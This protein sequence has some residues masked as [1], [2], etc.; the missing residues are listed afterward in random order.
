MRSETKVNPMIHVPTK[1]ICDEPQV[2]SPTPTTVPM[3]MLID[4]L[5]PNARTNLFAF[6]KQSFCV[7]TRS[8]KSKESVC[9]ERCGCEFKRVCICVV[10][11]ILQ[12][13][14]FKLLTTNHKA[15]EM[16]W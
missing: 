7:P 8:I 9:V 3:V 12:K 6:I 15:N 5:S 11:I 13:G 4:S 1:P 2:N 16:T 14:C 10:Y